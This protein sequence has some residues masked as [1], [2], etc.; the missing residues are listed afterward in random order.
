MARYCGGPHP[1]PG[2]RSAIVSL[3]RAGAGEPSCAAII[4]AGAPVDIEATGAGPESDAA[5]L[6]RTVNALRRAR[7][8]LS[9]GEPTWPWQRRLL[10]V[11]AV[12]ILATTI[13]SPAATLWLLLA[14]L[15]LPFTCV[16]LL[17]AAALWQDGPG[18]A[19]ASPDRISDASLP[20]YSI[21]VPLFREAEIVPG[22]V[23]AL[24]R[25]DYPAAKL[26]IL[27][28]V[29]EIDAETQSALAAAS[30][31]ASTRVVVVPDGTPRTKPR[32]LDYALPNARGDYVVVYDA[33]DVPDPDQLRRA[34]AAFRA[35]PGLACVQAR[36]AIENSSES[37]LTR[38]FAIEYLVLFDRLLPT[39]E[40]LRLPVPLGGTSNHFPR[41][42]LEGAGAWDPFNVTEDADLGVRLAR[43]GH[44]VAVLPSTT[45]EEAPVT[46]RI[47]L[48][49]RT[50][51]LKGWMQTYLV[52]MRQPSRLLNELGVWG[53]AGFQV[54]MGGLILSA[55]V[56]PWFY[57]LAALDVGF[58]V[59]SLPGDLPAASALWWIG[60]FNLAAGY[61]TGL[62][63]GWVAVMRRGRTELALHTL[64]MPVYW[65]LISAAAYRALWQLVAAPYLWEKTR[66]RARHRAA[67]A[68][69]DQQSI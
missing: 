68:D 6:D 4:G 2:E 32:A 14:A 26:Q 33:E 69:P 20:S 27:F 62:A 53:F 45:W 43:L 30:L 48:G 51:W 18:T 16:V 50:R 42:V 12:A 41:A 52:H 56:H 58:G 66:H 61:A 38:Q 7:P 46:F 15:A 24:S 28:I 11:G 17:R 35:R 47:W 21:L 13:A 19:P 55:L 8:E 37:W 36:L 44:E 22:L 3:R 9:A 63:L 31:P 39:L 60:A 1:R 65:L 34:A 49:Q 54:L 40:R 59:L 64:L 5:R 29:E 10:L 67:S 23:A 57:V 25:L